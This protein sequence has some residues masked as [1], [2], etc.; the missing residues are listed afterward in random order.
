MQMKKLLL[1]PMVVAACGGKQAP[2]AASDSKTSASDKW[3]EGG[4]ARLRVSDGGSGEPAIVL[5]HGLAGG[6][7]V[8]AGQLEHLR[9][10]HRVVAYDQRGHGESEPAKDGVYSMEAMAEDV[11]RVRTEL[12]LGKIVVVG[13]SMSGAVLST[14]AG[15]HPDAVAGL[16]FLDAIG[17]FSAFPAE[18]VKP[19]AAQAAA[20][21]P[22]TRTVVNAGLARVDG[23]AFT[24]LSAAMFALRDAGER[25]AP[26]QGPSIAIE[27]QGNELPFVASK[28]FGIERVEIAGVSHWLHLDDPAAIN[29]ALDGFLAKLR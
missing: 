25:I 13:H 10:S 26:Y 18:E 12:G 1:I 24:E 3:V 2:Q 14:Y 23:K 22:A 29:A 28:V 4:S 6:R 5:L 27:A 21:R 19:Y 11:E 7:E 17:D 16:V 15:K 20:A 8:W 9:R